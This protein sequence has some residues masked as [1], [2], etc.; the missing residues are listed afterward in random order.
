MR[1]GSPRLRILGLESDDYSVFAS[2]A[3]AR[4]FVGIYSKHLGVDASEVMEAMGRPGLSGF[5]GAPL[6]PR[7][8]MVPQDT[9][10]PIIKG[11]PESR[12]RQV[13]SVLVPLM[14]LAI[15]LL[16][17]TTFLLG[18]GEWAK[19]RAN[20]SRLPPCKARRLGLLFPL[21]RSRLLQTRF[22]ST[23]PATVACLPLLSSRRFQIPSWMRSSAG[24]PR[25]R[26]CN[27]E[28]S[29]DGAGQI[30]R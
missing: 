29:L 17:P 16:L 13:K 8:E 19:P 14:V 15:L 4:S 21:A 27:R 10:I 24:R 5:C 1:P 7:I 18:Q 20:L 30:R 12:P 6:S 9:I 28:F 26:P 22:R 2:L 23:R 11:L 3:Y 25:R